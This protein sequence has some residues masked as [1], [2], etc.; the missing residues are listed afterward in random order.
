M[1][2]NEIV[3]E[4]KTSGTEQNQ[5]VYRRHGASG[6]LYGVSFSRLRALAKRIKKTADVNKTALQLWETN[7][8]D[9][10]ILACMIVDTKTIAENIID[11]WIDDISYYPL[12]DE[13]TIMVSKTKHAHT[14]ALNWINSGNEFTVRIGYGLINE[15]TRSDQTLD[16][17]YFVPFIDKIAEEIHHMPNRAK[18]GMNNCLIAIGGRN[19]WLKKLVFQAA[20]VIGPVEIDHGETGCKTFQIKEYVQRIHEHKNRKSLPKVKQN[21]K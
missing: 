8:I 14:K 15:Q 17:S 7:N 2:Y 19:N 18:E 4:L 10:R 3:T 5:K 1:K 12:A 21:T 11:A 16:T 6:D 13:F 9:A 20:D